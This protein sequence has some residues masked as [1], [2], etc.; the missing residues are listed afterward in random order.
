MEAMPP[1]VGGRGALRRERET[2]KAFGARL[3]S[4]GVLPTRSSFEPAALCLDRHTY[5]VVILFLYAKL[6]GSLV[7]TFAYFAFCGCRVLSA[8]FLLRLRLH[9]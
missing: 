9:R 4:S 5:L 2:E 6:G 7:F 3:Q 1:R 8:L